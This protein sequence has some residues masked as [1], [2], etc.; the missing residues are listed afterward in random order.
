MAHLNIKYNTQPSDTPEEV[1]YFHFINLVEE[2][3]D[4]S[5]EARIF[6][7]DNYPVE[8]NYEYYLANSLDEEGDHALLFINN[9]IFFQK[10]SINP[11]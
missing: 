11:N 10:G 7:H 4:A 3:P 1:P 8:T 2:N 5:I 6:G 9:H